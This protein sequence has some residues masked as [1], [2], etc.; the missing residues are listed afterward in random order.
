MSVS[1]AI[2][3]LIV[4][5]L[6]SD[7]EVTAAGAGVY[8]SVPKSATYPYIHV[9]ESDFMADDAECVEAGVETFQLHIWTLEHGKLASCRALTGAVRVALHGAT[10]VTQAL[11]P[12]ALVS[13]RVGLARV[14]RDPDGETSH[15][16]VQVSC[17]YEE[18]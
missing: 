10:D 13:M 16:V 8:D 9:G 15:G 6:R 11:D 1:V 5:L 7:P 18:G 12:H 2:Q 14:M 4:F 17:R 3:E